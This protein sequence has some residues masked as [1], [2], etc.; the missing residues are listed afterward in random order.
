MYCVNA[1]VKLALI[2]AGISLPVS[3]CDG[4]VPEKYSLLTNLHF[5]VLFFKLDCYN[6]P[7]ISNFPKYSGKP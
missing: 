4:M 5:V 1:K 2:T 6:Y 7:L 3:R